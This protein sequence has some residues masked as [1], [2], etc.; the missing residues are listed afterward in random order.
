MTVGPCWLDSV[1]S[2]TWYLF[3]SCCSEP[4]SAFISSL[5]TSL[6]IMTTLT[7]Y[8]LPDPLLLTVLQETGSWEGA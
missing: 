3:S 4:Q 5:S 6:S 2:Y 1:A 8:N 7:R